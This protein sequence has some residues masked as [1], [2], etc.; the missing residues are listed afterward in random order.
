MTPET[1]KVIISNVLDY[2]FKPI[3]DKH[4]TV[5]YDIYECI[6]TV[7]FRHSNRIFRRPESE[8]QVSD[9]KLDPL[10]GELL[11]EFNKHINWYD[12]AMEE[13]EAVSW[14]LSEMTT[15]CKDAYSLM[16]LMPNSLRVHMGFEDHNLIQKNRMSMSENQVIT[17]KAERS[18]KYALLDSAILK[19]T[20][21]TN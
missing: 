11:E 4:V 18:A 14:F 13:R 12:A 6:E 5:L 15:K 7:G 21:L 3:E 9:V 2:I 10:S 17:W 19:R 20:L 1:R 16:L 8:A